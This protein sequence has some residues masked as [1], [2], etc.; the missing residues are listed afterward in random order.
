MRILA[1]LGTLVPLLAAAQ[2]GPTI[3]TPRAPERA[4]PRFASVSPAPENPG[5][6]VARTRHLLEVVRKYPA[7]AN[8]RRYSV[9]GVQ[10]WPSQPITREALAI[11]DAE[12]GAYNGALRDAVLDCGTPVA[13]PDD[14]QVVLLEARGSRMAV[15]V[16]LT[17]EGRSLEYIELSLDQPG[18]PVA[19]VVTGYN[20]LAIRITSSAQTRL[21]AVHLNTYYPNVI[22]GFDSKRVTQQYHGRRGGNCNYGFSDGV[23]APTVLQRL[24]RDPQKVTRYQTGDNWQVA[25]GQP[26]PV[27]RTAPVLGNFLDLEMPVPSNY[28]IVVLSELGYIRPMQVKGGRENLRGDAFEV[29]KPFRLP[30]GMGGAHSV[31]F[32]LNPDSP[33]P[34]GNLLHSQMVRELRPASQ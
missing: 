25:I 5:H 32:I 3:L 18:A 27:R 20:A 4:E 23:H 14:V 28:G 6:F 30:E 12:R 22:L 16:F 17:P 11:L 10:L 8:D 2:A 33:V 15:P 31:A 19:L 34:S 9:N 29:L 7:G 24:G 21:A 1:L 13:L 26:Q